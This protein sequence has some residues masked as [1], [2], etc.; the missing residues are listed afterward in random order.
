MRLPT[1]SGAVSI[2]EH[3][4]VATHQRCPE[5]GEASHPGGCE[6]PR[7]TLLRG[8]NASPGKPR[9]VALMAAA[10]PQ[11]WPWQP[12]WLA[13]SRCAASAMALTDTARSRWTVAL[14]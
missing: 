14:S 4:T 9:S 7:R 12:R 10:R 5:R 6:G 8:G 3:R 1:A 11:R 13:L 2:R